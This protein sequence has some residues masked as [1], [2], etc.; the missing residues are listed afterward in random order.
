MT[1]Q[2][3]SHTCLSGVMASLLLTVAVVE[4]GNFVFCPVTQV[5]P[6]S[7]VP[8]VN[9]ATP[10]EAVAWKCGSFCKLYNWVFHLSRWTANEKVLWCFSSWHYGIASPCCVSSVIIVLSTVVCY[11]LVVCNS[12]LKQVCDKVGDAAMSVVP[13]LSD[14]LCRCLSEG[15]WGRECI[16]QWAVWVSAFAGEEPV[17]LHK[18]VF[19]FLFYCLSAYSG[20]CLILQ[21][22]RAICPPVKSGGWISS[23][24]ANW[25]KSIKKRDKKARE[26]CKVGFDCCCFVSSPSTTNPLTLAVTSKSSFRPQSLVTTVNTT[27]QYYKYI[28]KSGHSRRNDKC[29]GTLFYRLF[30][31]LKLPE[32]II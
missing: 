27:L 13:C 4:S 28:Y 31:S 1:G 5:V 7:F 16:N 11:R 21:R 30:S 29:I 18:S 14:A 22:R 20:F 25:R 19:S 2:G 26:E 6:G 17:W 12:V 32:L 9:V 23:W 24:S 10:R 3:P 8:A 15:Q